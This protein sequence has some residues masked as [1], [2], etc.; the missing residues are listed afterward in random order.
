VL[1]AG[2]QTGAATADE[3]QFTQVRETLDKCLAKY[4]GGAVAPVS[5]NNFTDDAMSVSSHPVDQ[6]KES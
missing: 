5:A 4:G 1:P 3:D 6:Q 2:T